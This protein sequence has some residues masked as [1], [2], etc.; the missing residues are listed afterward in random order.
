MCDLQYCRPK[1][2]D[3]K[4]L[5]NHLNPVMLVFLRLLLLSIL[6]NH[7]DH[8]GSMQTREK[9]A[10]YGFLHHVCATG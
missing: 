4:I 3:A 1:Q 9:V 5:E 2:K 6:M 7:S 10:R 8:I